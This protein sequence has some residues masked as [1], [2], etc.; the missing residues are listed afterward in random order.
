MKECLRCKSQKVVR[1]ATVEWSSS[2]SHR[3]TFKPD[4]LKFTAMS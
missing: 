4:N 3:Q 1:G 2:T